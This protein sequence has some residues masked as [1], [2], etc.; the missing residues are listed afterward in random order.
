M[1]W[2]WGGGS[3]HALSPRWLSFFCLCSVEDRTKPV[4]A[5]LDHTEYTEQLIQ[6]DGASDIEQS[7]WINT[8]GLLQVNSLTGFLWLS[9]FFCLFVMSFYLKKSFHSSLSFSLRVSA[10]LYLFLN[11]CQSFYIRDPVQASAMFLDKKNF[12]SLLLAIA[13]FRPNSPNMSLH[14][15]NHCNRIIDFQRPD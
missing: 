12:R 2:S 13:V 15:L 9:V 11:V 8:T 5:P 14:A 10:F 1:K 4:V 3:K 7:A 6:T